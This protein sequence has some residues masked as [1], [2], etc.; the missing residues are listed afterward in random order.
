MTEINDAWKGLKRAILTGVWYQ[1]QPMLK[2][3]VARSGS[4]FK[5]INIDCYLLNVNFAFTVSLLLLQ[6][7]GDSVWCVGW[8]MKYLHAYVLYMFC[9]M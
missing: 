9:G 3:L 4:Y 7:E 8:K 1:G 5:K 2:L 6:M